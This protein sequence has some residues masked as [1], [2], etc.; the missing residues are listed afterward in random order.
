MKS[1]LSRVAL[2]ICLLLAMVIATPLFADQ[3]TY[4][5]TGTG[6]DGSLS[7]SAAFTTSAGQI[8][9]SL[10]NLLAANAIRSAG[11][12][13]SDISFTLSNSPGTLGSV[14]ASGQLGNVSSTGVVT[15]TS[16]SP[17]RWLGVGG[18]VFSIIGNTITLEVIGGGQPSQMIAPAIANGGTYTNANGG[19]G[20]FNPYVIGPATF[21]IS[22]SGVTANT[23]VT[24]ATFSFGT[25]PDTFLPG[26][27]NSPL[28]TPEPASM[29]LL[30]SGF[31]ALSR[32]K[33]RS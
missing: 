24:S 32:L 6:S 9:V 19:F 20:N 8:T 16:G 5:G 31:A 17:S 28:T 25:G 18:G 30:A 21:T 3:I 15:Y 33:R 10:T 13:L 27:P 4:T 12:A 29:L 23:Q 7:A 1:P 11:Q 22:L 2:A 14:S 26:T